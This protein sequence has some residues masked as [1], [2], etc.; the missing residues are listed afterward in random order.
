MDDADSFSDRWRLKMM[1]LDH[2]GSELYDLLCWEHFLGDES[3]NDH[4]ANIERLGGL[5]HRDPEALV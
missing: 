4:V 3:A 1:A 5:L 2:P